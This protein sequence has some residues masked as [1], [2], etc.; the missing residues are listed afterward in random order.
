MRPEANNMVR[1]TAISLILMIMLTFGTAFAY[2]DDQA[3]TEATERIQE[4]VQEQPPQSSNSPQNSDSPQNS[5]K[6]GS[7]NQTQTQTQTVA[8]APKPKPVSR[9]IK[10]GKYYYYKESNGK[11][12]KKAGFVTDLGKRYYIKKGGKIVTGKTF[13]VKKKQYRAYGSGV[14]A[15]GIYKWGGKYYYSDSYGQWIKKEKIVS[16][17][18]NKYYLDK[19]G[20]VARNTAFGYNNVPYKAD[21]K[22]RL[23][24]LTIPDGGGNAVVAVA[25]KQVGI[26]TGKKYWKWY[27]KTRFR[28]SDVTPWCGTFVAWCYHQ[29]GLYN[30]VSGVRRYGNLGYVPSYAR[31]ANTKGKWV[32]KSAAQ[33][34]DI[35]IFARNMHVGIVEGVVDGCIITIEGN[36]S[37]NQTL[38]WGRNGFVA[39]RAFTMNDKKIK[40]IIHPY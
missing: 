4:Q 20:V 13:K 25:K 34:G 11:I 33:P 18:G 26:K 15:T 7:G 24:T 12:R 39:R 8:P 23:T 32:K 29:A 9:I 6:A 28:N 5:E 19:K 27:F 30:K 17:K 22:G 37:I 31:Y 1:R 10:K 35:V 38:L 3:P 21:A 16:W 14:I 2:A 36:T 40:G